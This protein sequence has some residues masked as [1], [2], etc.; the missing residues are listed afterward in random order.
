MIKKLFGE[1]K[2]KKIAIDQL[3][4]TS[5]SYNQFSKRNRILL[6]SYCRNK[7][8]GSDLPNELTFVIG[9]EAADADSVISSLLYAFYKSKA[10]QNEKTYI[11]VVS[12]P[13]EQLELRC[14]IVSLLQALRIDLQDVHFVDEIDWK[15]LIQKHKTALSWILVDHN[16][17]TNKHIY[18]AVESSSHFDI[19]SLDVKEIIDHHQDQNKYLQAS[20]RNV[21]FQDSRALVGSCCTLVAEQL[22]STRYIPD[23]ATKS[24]AGLLSTLLL[25]VIS[26]DT[27]NFDSSAK[28]ATSRDVAMAKWLDSYSYASTDCLYEW[29]AAQKSNEEHW[30]KFSFRNCLDYD[31]KE[32][33]INEWSGHRF[34]ISSVLISLE[35]VAAK[36]GTKDAFLNEL[37]EFCCKNSIKFLIIMT[38]ERDNETQAVKREV[39][40]YEDGPTDYTKQCLNYLVIDKSNDLRLLPLPDFEY[41]D[42]DHIRVFRQ[43]NVAAS[44]KQLV[45]LLKE[46]LNSTFDGSQSK[47]EA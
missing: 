24:E 29:L 47:T 38:I 27:I 16:H 5:D 17:L 12:I 8:D 36:C 30:K 31:Y 20:Y 6:S 22:R 2:W 35:K 43:C 14:E 7:R 34:G 41:Q 19:D 15:E 21:A 4:T 28:K 26:L 13:R 9:N 10:A 44:R 39:L 11:P 25:S 23:Q 33:G 32:F 3:E 46:A 37:N 45:P 18:Q 40:F 42:T 1:P